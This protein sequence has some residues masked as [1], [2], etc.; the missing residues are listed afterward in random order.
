MDI[1]GFEIHAAEKLLFVEK[2]AAVVT[3]LL[4]LYKVDRS[5][6]A[7]PIKVDNYLKKT[8]RSP[9]WWKSPKYMIIWVYPI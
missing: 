2:Q 7:D 3:G 1:V 8:L 4:A 9:K 6:S 5:T